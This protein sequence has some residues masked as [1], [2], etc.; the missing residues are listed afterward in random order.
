MKQMSRRDRV[1]AAV[2]RQPVDRVP[3]GDRVGQ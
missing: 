1:M 3:E 2:N